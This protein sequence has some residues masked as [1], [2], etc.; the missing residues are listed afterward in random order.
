VGLVTRKVDRVGRFPITLN[1]EKSEKVEW[2]LF[3]EQVRKG[4][5]TNLLEIVKSRGTGARKEK[6]NENLGKKKTIAMFRF[7]DK[8]R[9]G[10]LRTRR[11]GQ[12][13]RPEGGEIDDR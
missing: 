6:A 8:L 10:R 7:P 13:S 1:G 4:A 2:F 11:G 5:A 9:R 3:G 12:P